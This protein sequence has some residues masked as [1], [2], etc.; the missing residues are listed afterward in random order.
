MDDENKIFRTRLVG[1]W[2]LTNAALVVAIQ[3]INGWLNLDDPNLTAAKVNQFEFDWRSKRDVYFEVVLFATFGLTLIRFIG[4]RICLFF[5]AT[6]DPFCIVFYL[7]CELPHFSLVQ[8]TLRCLLHTICSSTGFF[9]FYSLA[10]ASNNTLRPFISSGLRISSKTSSVNH[11][12]T[13]FL[14]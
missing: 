3:N 14:A 8:Q 11:P 2:M 9:L 13:T 4:V 5:E 7:L 6:T 10:N 1:F 12:L